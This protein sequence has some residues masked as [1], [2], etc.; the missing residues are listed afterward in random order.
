MVC[1]EW[2]TL[3]QP[4]LCSHRHLDPHAEGSHRPGTEQRC[5]QKEEGQGY[6]ENG[7]CGQCLPV[8]AEHPPC[9]GGTN[10]LVPLVFRGNTSQVH[11]RPTQGPWLLLG[12]VLV[13]VCCYDKTPRPKATVE[14]KF[15]GAFGSR[16]IRVFMVGSMAARRQALWLAQMTLRAQRAHILNYKHEGSRESKQK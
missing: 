13:S 12:A 5:G 15:T 16:G 11:C 14:E 9:R 6:P 10:V 3:A 1:P 2:N 4:L 8:L 7:A